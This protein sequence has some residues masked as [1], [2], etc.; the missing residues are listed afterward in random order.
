MLFNLDAIP[1]NEYDEGKLALLEEFGEDAE[2][3]EG[4]DSINERAV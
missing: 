4:N 1:L 3:D 2:P